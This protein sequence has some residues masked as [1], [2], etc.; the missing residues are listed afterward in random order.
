MISLRR[1]SQIVFLALFLFLMLYPYPT[2]NVIPTN[3]F[4]ISNPLLSIATIIATR[5]FV[6]TFLT[7]LVVILASIF[8]GRV[9][10]G[11]VCPLGT[12]MDIFR[13]IAK[14]KMKFTPPTSTSEYLKQVKYF[15]L[16]IIIVIAIFGINIVGSFDPITIVFK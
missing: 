3:L 12:T 5:A 15:I 7:S 11:W 9:F 10:C 6:A 16:L 8:L 14:P 4:F 1:F 13:K 2:K